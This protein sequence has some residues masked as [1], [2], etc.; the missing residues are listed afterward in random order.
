[1]FTTRRD[2]KKK[3]RKKNVS[4]WLVNLTSATSLVWNPSR[5]Q[6]LLSFTFSSSFGLPSEIQ[7][8][9]FP[10]QQ[11]ASFLSEGKTRVISPDVC[12]G[13]RSWLARWSREGG[14]MLLRGR[15]KKEAGVRSPFRG[16]LFVA[17]LAVGL[18]L[19]YLAVQYSVWNH[20]LVL[21]WSYRTCVFTSQNRCKVMHPA[22]RA[23][24]L[25]SIVPRQKD[26]EYVSSYY[27]T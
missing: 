8:L 26:S 14:A 17:A 21:L 4:H 12:I 24:A 20:D 27:H 5:T 13:Q 6:C 10:V 2:R 18:L 22:F 25:F 7:S 16:V 3:E 23:G 9:F 19:E 11:L 15:R 1:M